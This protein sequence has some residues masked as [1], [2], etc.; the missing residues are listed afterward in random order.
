MDSYI[1]TVCLCVY[2]SIFEYVLGAREPVLKPVH[3]YKHTCM[4]T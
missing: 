2:A 4:N 3:A 1:Y